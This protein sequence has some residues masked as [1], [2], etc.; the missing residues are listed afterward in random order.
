LFL[1]VFDND[2]ER[3]QEA[4]GPELIGYGQLLTNVQ[5]FHYSPPSADS[6]GGR[7]IKPS[8]ETAFAALV[9]A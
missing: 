5:V 9:S 4:L 2:F 6:D 3:L 8:H 7:T 1:L